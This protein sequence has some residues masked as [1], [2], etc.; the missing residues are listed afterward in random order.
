MKYKFPYFDMSKDLLVINPTS[1]ICEKCGYKWECRK[2][3]D[4]ENPPASCPRC[5][6][7]KISHV[8]ANK[9]QVEHWRQFYPTDSF[10]II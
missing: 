3:H 6:S 4:W 2:P 8:K 9:E 1:F 5:K 10:R 7:R